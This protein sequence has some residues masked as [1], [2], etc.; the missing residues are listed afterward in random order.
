MLILP[1]SY[2]QPV[3]SYNFKRNRK[4]Q[5]RKREV[6]TRQMKKP[7]W[8][9]TNRVIAN[10]V[11][12]MMMMMMMMMMMVRRR[13][14][15][16]SLSLEYDDKVW[17]HQS[18][19]I[20]VMNIYVYENLCDEWRIFQ[21]RQS[22]LCYPRLTSSLQTSLRREARWWWWLRWWWWWQ[23]RWSSSCQRWS[24]TQS[25]RVATTGLQNK[26]KRAKLQPLLS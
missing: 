26:A 16:R 11:T 1:G 13:R 5:T 15:R 25:A 3:T 17:G 12:T 24:T 2:R 22:L 10:I 8:T 9:K 19:N 20:H 14:R 4:A 23:W 18:L 7:S 6:L 21:V